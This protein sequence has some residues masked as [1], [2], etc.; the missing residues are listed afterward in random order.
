M[1]LLPPASGFEWGTG[2][3]INPVPP[4]QAATFLKEIEVDVNAPKRT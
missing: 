3:Y 1:S 2:F 4:E